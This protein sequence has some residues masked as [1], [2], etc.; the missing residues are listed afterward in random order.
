M[1]PEAESNLFHRHLTFE[2][3]TSRIEEHHASDEPQDQM[4]IIPVFSLHLAHLGG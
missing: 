1:M 3:H 2:K 4:A